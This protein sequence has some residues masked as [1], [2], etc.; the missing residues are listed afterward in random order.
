MKGKK[1]K[2]ISCLSWRPYAA[3]ELAVGTSIGVI[4]WKIDQNSI[5]IR[6]SMANAIIL[7]QMNVASITWNSWGTLLITASSFYGNILVW[8]CEQNKNEKVWCSR[9]GVNLVT[10]A[11]ST[12]YICSSDIQGTCR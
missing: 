5:Q 4:L 11:M 9:I 8:N 6:P 7:K 2:D 12:H 3:F 10:W 1:Q